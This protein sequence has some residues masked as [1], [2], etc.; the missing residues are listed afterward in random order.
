[1]ARRG[2]LAPINSIKHYVQFTNTA[3]A[4]G[5]AAGKEIAKAVVAPA[6]GTTS[7]VREGSVIKAV[8][9]E[10]WLNS[11]AAT[12]AESQFTLIVEKRPSAS[13][14]LSFTDTQNLMAY[15]NKK[16]ILYVT[17][18]IIGATVDGNGSVPVVRQFFLI[19][20]GKQR[21]GSD[22]KIVVTVGAVGAMRVCGFSTYKEYT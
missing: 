7:E 18:G 2:M 6:V 9:I 3:L 17:Q 1:M 22:D 15:T 12:G 14:S 21:M 8:Y 5:A 20:K 13:P 10:F 4:S 16:N 11:E 19:P